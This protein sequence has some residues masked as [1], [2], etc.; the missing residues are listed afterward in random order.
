MY[1]ALMKENLRPQNS[2]KSFKEFVVGDPWSSNRVIY[3]FGGN[4]F[5]KAP[6]QFRLTSLP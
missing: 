1:K 6:H 3:M 5:T 2:R 4:D